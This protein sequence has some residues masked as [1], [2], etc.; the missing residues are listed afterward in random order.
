MDHRRAAEQGLQRARDAAVAA[1]EAKGQWLANMSHEIRTPLNGIVNCV[2]LCLDTSLDGEQTEFLQL[3]RSTPR[4][5]PTI[6]VLV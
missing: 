6:A 2:E 5:G 3:V 4:V 1:D